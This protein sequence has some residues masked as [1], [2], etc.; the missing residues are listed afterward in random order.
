MRTL[1]TI[2]V[3]LGVLAGGTLVYLAST[4]PEEAEGVRL[5]L[6]ETHRELLALVPASAEAFA[7]IPTAAAVHAK[8]LANP[9]TRD[10]LLEWSREHEMP[11]RWMLGRAHVAVWK[12]GKTT[13]Y[14]VRF[15]RFRA[16]LVR[17]W[18]LTASTADAH[19]YGST[20]VMHEPERGPSFV[21]ATTVVEQLG[22]AASGLP[23]GDALVVQQARS[24]GAFP[25]IPRPAITTIRVSPATIDLVSRARAEDDP[26]EELATNA[27]M[28][29][30]FPRQAVLSAAFASPPS[31]LRD[32]NRL[33]G[34]DID[35]LV[36]QGG[37]IAL[38][39][40]ESG[41]LLPRPRAVIV[42]PADEAS[43]QQMQR[44]ARVAELVGETRDTGEHLLVSFDRTSMRLYLEDTLVPA[45]W[46]SNAWALRIDP[47][48]LVPILEDAA[49]SAGLRF[50]AGR[51]H[52]AARDLRGWIGALRNAKSIE[53][54]RS[55]TPAVEELR[56]RVVSK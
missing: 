25:P 9:V 24:R 15:D 42:L 10:P 19:W 30:R 47:A 2:I 7:L 43:R 14:A 56:V 32:L 1:I 20:L 55:T 23:E 12:N 21:P 26:G 39:G 44:V 8:L 37:Q 51:L 45:S 50:A 52:R 22:T 54:G 53:A 35:D 46:P 5:P 13:S 40:V 31:I 38:Y 4:T 49:D 33:L 17:L 18:L 41:T 3:I 29:P 27:P 28:T 16:L 11:R 6:R 36:D 48:G 34:A